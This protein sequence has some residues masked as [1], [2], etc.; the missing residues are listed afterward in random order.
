MLKELTLLAVFGALGTLA[1]Y[2]LSGWVQRLGGAGFPWGTLAV[3]ALGCLLFGLV[4]ALAEERLLI[5]G[6]TRFILLTGFMGAFTTFSTFAFE[7]SQMLRDGEW[8]LAG[9]NLV[10]QNLLG[11]LCMAAGIAVGRWL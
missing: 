3:N 10:A 4:W 9:L 8:L 2:G 6:Q 1:R 11:L 5:S 7:S